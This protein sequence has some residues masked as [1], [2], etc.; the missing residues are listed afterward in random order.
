MEG[1][2]IIP[3]SISPTTAG[4]RTRSKSSPK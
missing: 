2:I 3:L 1:P 4:R